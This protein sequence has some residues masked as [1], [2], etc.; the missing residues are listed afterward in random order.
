MRKF[1]NLRKRKCVE[2]REPL[3]VGVDVASEAVLADGFA[4]VAFVIAGGFAVAFATF[5][6][7]GGDDFGAGI[8]FA[9]EDDGQRRRQLLGMYWPCS[10]S[11]LGRKRST[12]I[13]SS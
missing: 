11:K 6:K 8:E 10:S 1:S 13:W 3:R 7:G 5:L 2:L 12:A 9:A 4:E